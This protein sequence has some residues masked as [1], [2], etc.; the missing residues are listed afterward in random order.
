MKQKTLYFILAICI[1][2]IVILISLLYK[3]NNPF[4]FSTIFRRQQWPTGAY[5]ILNRTWKVDR[6]S[7]VST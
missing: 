3:N 2:I 1:L 4:L 7:H 5:R 6:Q